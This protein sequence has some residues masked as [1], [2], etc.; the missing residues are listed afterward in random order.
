MK[1]I[2]FRIDFQVPDNTPADKVAL[3]Q[4]ILHNDI[5]A[6]MEPLRRSMVDGVAVHLEAVR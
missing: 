2:S 1:Q 6:Q 5:K 4:E 3:I